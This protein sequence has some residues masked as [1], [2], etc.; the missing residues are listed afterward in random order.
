MKIYLMRKRIMLR[1]C[2][3]PL[4]VPSFV[5]AGSEPGVL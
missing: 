4:A 3:K 5:R 1:A 2:K